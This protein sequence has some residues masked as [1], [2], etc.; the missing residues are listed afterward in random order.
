LKWPVPYSEVW[1]LDNSFLNNLF[2]TAG[3][4][5]F[6]AVGFVLFLFCAGK[7]AVDPFLEKGLVFAMVAPV[8]L[9][10]LIAVT[11]NAPI[12]ETN[13]ASPILLYFLIVIVPLD[14]FSIICGFF[15]GFRGYRIRNIAWREPFFIL[16]TME[17][18]RGFGRS[19]LLIKT[20]FQVEPKF[21]Q[22]NFS[23]KPIG[24]FHNFLNFVSVLLTVTFLEPVC[25]HAIGIMFDDA[26]IDFCLLASSALVCAVFAAICGLFRTMHR[27]ATLTAHWS[28]G[29]LGLQ[30]M[31]GLGVVGVVAVEV[32]GRSGAWTEISVILAGAVLACLVGGVV[33]SVGVFASYGWSLLVCLV[34][35][36]QG[37]PG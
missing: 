24:I 21:G 15:G 18:A 12:D 35:Y 1:R 23:L 9:T 2:F 33:M 14:A 11:L 30:A 3:G 32:L 37:K 29:S 19:A 6:L 8:Q 28:Q 17:M 16:L 31:V 5:M 10:S 22:S 27:T 13:Y 4:L 26:P 34:V 36:A 7:R 20:F 25:R